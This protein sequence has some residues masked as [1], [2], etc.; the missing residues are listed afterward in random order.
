MIV[1]AHHH[2]W[3]LARGDYEW[4]TPHLPIHRD[5][6]LEDLR[7]VLHEIDATVLASK[8]VL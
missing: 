5:Y 7:P 6:G 3:R 1:D 2:V 8:T 4:L